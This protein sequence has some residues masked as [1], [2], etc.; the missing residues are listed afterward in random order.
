MARGDSFRVCPKCGSRNKAKWDF[1]V[2]CG[3]SLGDATVTTAAPPPAEIVSGPPEAEGSQGLFLGFLALFVVAVAGSVWWLSRSSAPPPVTDSR[4][5]AAPAKPPSLPPPQPATGLASLNALTDPKL[6]EARAKLDANDVPGAIALLQELVSNNPDYAAAHG[7]YGYALLLSGNAARA[8]SEYTRAVQID[9]SNVQYRIG[10]ASALNFADKLD[11]SV[12]EYEK[13]LQLSPDPKI[14]EDLGS[15]LLRQKNDPAAAL[16]H[17]RKA[18][19]DEPGNPKYAEQ[20]AL[21]LEATQDL[22]GA[23]K[24]YQKVLETTP[25]ASESRGRLAEILFTQGRSDDAIA[26]TKA[27]IERDPAVPILHRNLGSFLERSGK[28]MEASTA[29]G[30]YAR[31]APN[32]PDAAAI[33][34]RAGALAQ[35][36]ASGSP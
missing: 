24:V 36:A 2:R 26:L 13:V 4:L 5:F 20:Y 19:A 18:A 16:P 34:D 15:L 30:E 7:L 6:A 35:Q 23:K 8:V 1:C 12:A 9:P 25:G 21:A 32:A 31:L 29:Y 11:E 28:L 17:L 14:E 27:G 22:E 33:K 10:R 3:E